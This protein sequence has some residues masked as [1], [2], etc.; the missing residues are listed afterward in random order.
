MIDRNTIVEVPSNAFITSKGDV[1]VKDKNLYD[2]VLRYN[3][4]KHTILG[5][6]IGGGKMYPNS[7]Y[8]ARYPALYEEHSGQKAT[9]H[10]I[11]TG[12]YASVLSIAS[13][14]GLYDSLIKGF[15]VENANMI[16]DFSMYS[17][18]NHTCV[19]DNY[20]SK[21]ADQMIF[22]RSLW[23][24]SRLSE[25][26]NK[27]FTEPRI[28]TFKKEWAEKCKARGLKKVWIA[29]DGSNND[30]EATKASLSEKGN[31]KSHKNSNI[32]SYMY[33][34]DAS[35][36]DPISIIIY[37]G[38]RV[39]CKA[40]MELIG[41]LKA[42]EMETMG[43]LID[44]GFATNEVLKKLEDDKID[45][46]VMLKGNTLA[47]QTMLNKYAK[48]LRADDDLGY[49]LGLFKAGQ[50]DCTSPKTISNGGPVL[51]GTSSKQKIKIFASHGHKAFAHLIYDEKNGVDRKHTWY[52]KV[53]GMAC[54]L[55]RKL[56][57]DGKVSVPSEYKDCIEVNGDT[58]SVNIKNTC[59]AGSTK[60]FYTL[61]TSFS[62][63]AEE[64]SGHYSLRNSSEEQYSILKSQIGAGVTGVHYNEGIRAK[65]I[66]SFVTSII[67]N[68]LMKVA[69]ENGIPTNRMINELNEIKIYM[70]FHDKYFVAHTENAKQIE[71]LKGCG[72]DPDVLDGIAKALNARP[73]KAEVNPIH[74]LPPKTESEEKQASRTKSGSANHKKKNSKSGEEP[75]VKRPKGRPKGSKNKKTIER[76]RLEALAARR[77]NG[78]NKSKPTNTPPTTS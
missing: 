43:V 55:Q 37:R 40:I 1:F 58:V 69:Q 47:H 70:D 24:P 48:K 27:E 32:V 71:I 67:R 73:E 36:G 64:A 4:V 50:R 29:I 25:F 31:A 22:S 3:H 66:V 44:R 49:M 57:K 19:S 33:V 78:A 61:S 75:K 42:Y 7:N 23:G 38:G 39:D 28:S 21:M 8:I 56:Y 54:A 16:L 77:K 76:E 20:K 72:L 15:G 2:P 30:C 41:W 62:C 13:N 11:R 17:I 34:V 35:T 63:N 45:Y 52:H 51:Y 74:S 26:F 18:I 46:V 60:G 10:E 9:R 5:Q 53:N 12:F 14:I 65:L 59:S 68:E 6:S